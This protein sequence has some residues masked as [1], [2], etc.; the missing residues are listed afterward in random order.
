VEPSATA[1]ADESS[2]RSDRRETLTDTEAVR[3]VGAAEA[4]AEPASGHHLEGV[5]S[6][7]NERSL[8][9]WLAAGDRDDLDAFDRYLHPDV[10][11]HAPLGLWT[12]GVEAEKA[13]WADAKRAM[14]DIRHDVQETLGSPSRAAARVIV[15]GTL[16]GEF[17]GIPA[18]GTTFE[19]DQMVFAHFRDGLIVEAW[20]VAD[21]ASVL[22]QVE[23]GDERGA[24]LPGHQ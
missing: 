1:T 17:A 22:R 6:E 8:R 11:V 15:T 14:P 18:T 5:S 23:D 20:E 16:R 7:D 2:L 9:E 19:I 4:T 3:G 24:A 12:T 21:T 13:V 10:V